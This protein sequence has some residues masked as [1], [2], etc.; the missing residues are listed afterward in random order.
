VYKLYVGMLWDNGSP[1]GGPNHYPK[2]ERITSAT[3]GLTMAGRTVLRNMQPETQGQSHQI[4]NITIGPDGKLYVHMGDGFTSS[5]ALNLDMYRGKILRMNLDGSAPTDN[6][7]YNAGD[8]FNAR[9]Y[10]FAYGFRNPFGGAWRASDGKHYEVENGNS[11]DR[12]AQ[13]NSGVNYGWNGNDSTML[14][15]AI[16]NWTPSS[17]PV[18][19]TF[20]QRETFGGSQFPASKMDHAFISQSGTTYAPGPQ[21]NGKR[22]TEFVLNASGGLVSGP[23][24]LIEYIGNGRSSVVGLA[25]GP[26]G[27]YFTELYEETGASGATA[28]GARIYRVRYV[29][30]IVGDYDIDGN[31]DND[32]YGVWRASVGS[33][34]LLAADGNRNG[35]VDTADYVVWRNAMAAA[36]AASTTVTAPPLAET[37][38]DTANAR[39][40]ASSIS[41]TGTPIGAAV[42]PPTLEVVETRSSALGQVIDLALTDL[43][44]S[45]SVGVAAGRSLLAQPRAEAK[46]DSGIS[47]LLT[48]PAEV[49]TDRLRSS[50]PSYDAAGSHDRR[51]A[52]DV[53]ELFAELDLELL[54]W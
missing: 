31:V 46:T 38:N 54:R 23:T 12:F 40:I 26:D 13:V 11:V 5:T 6:P 24:N 21:A 37:V 4:S 43:R 48:I 10:I 35:V 18:N 8:G 44:R 50:D 3:G 51:D 52:S 27:L 9:D 33:N 28:V 47:L 14:I 2:V 30:P 19:I 22:I 29:N 16:Y 1:A 45:T 39:A 49:R 36:A 17:A 32:D 53:D 34:L 42:N 7:F 15:N 25:A 20:V 41:P